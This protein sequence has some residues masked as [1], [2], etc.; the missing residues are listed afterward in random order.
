MPGKQTRPDAAG[1]ARCDSLQ[2]LVESLE[3]YGETTALTVFAEEGRRDVGFGALVRE[4]RRLAQAMAARGIGQ[5]TPVALFGTNSLD[6]VFC[7]FALI[8]ADALCVPIDFDADVARLQALVRDSGATHL[9]VSH[10]KLPTARKA[11]E[12]ERL[13]LELV[14][15]DAPPDADLDAPRLGE[16]EAPGPQE[17][18]TADPDAPV[19]RF[20]TSG[21]TGLPKAVPLSHRNILIN[22]EVLHELDLVGPGDAVLLPLPLHHSYPFIVGLLLPLWAGATV[23][24]PQGASGPA[25][26]SAL[27]EAGVTVIVGVPRLYEALADGIDRRIRGSGLLVGGLLRG[28]IAISRTLRRRFG[29]RVGRTLLAPLHRQLGP[30]LRLLVSGGAKLDEGVAWRLEA[31]GFQVL[32][33]YGLVE[34]TSVATFNPPG[35]ARLGSAGKVSRA[36]EVRLQPLPDMQHGEV[37]IRG[38]VLF[39]GYANSPEANA[40]SFTEDGWFRTGDLGELDAQGYLYIRGRAKEVIVLPGGKNVAPGD[41]EDVYGGSPHIREIAVLERGDRLVGLVVPESAPNE[42]ASKLESRIRVAIGELGQQLPGYMRLSDFVLT[43]EELPRNQLGKFKRHQ[44]EPIYDRAERGEAAAPRELSEEEKRT[45]ATPRARATLALLEAWYPDRRLHPDTSLQMELGI[46]SLAWVELSLEL[47]RRLGVSLGDEAMM[48]VA[49]L[50]DLLEAVE[51]APESRGGEDRGARLLRE[52]ERWLAEPGLAGRVAGGL[53]Y[54]LGWLLAHSYF[55]LS[56]SGREKVPR[57]GPLLV[58]ANHASD[59][60]GGILALALPRRTYRQTWWSGDAGR[61]FHTR[62]HRAFSRAQHIF[63]VDER[64][65]GAALELAGELLHRDRVLAWFP[66]EWRSPDGELQDFRPGIGVLV[67]RHRVPVLPCVIEGAFEVMPRT[68]RLP[69]PGRLRVRFGGPIAPEELLP[70]REVT[71]EAERHRRIA[72]A[73]RDRIAALQADG[74]QDAAGDGGGLGRGGRGRG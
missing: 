70:G 38:P 43:R 65:P 34:T 52:R 62:L 37:Q 68:A 27:Q 51:A 23:A 26:L 56:V 58:A 72:A 12:D 39:P 30:Q 33:G 42:A 8:L 31:L 3:R 2:A 61:L 20:Y 60:D 36:A 48:Q 21:T 45:L 6:W 69:K 41:V 29:L 19:A 1:A 22:I 18:P 40:E 15:L 7:R 17:L 66:E 67:D 25:L 73:L 53:I 10:D 11:V 49:T 13:E 47:E 44:L 28:L 63:P 59:I 55:R 64:S 71:D 24:F 9:F 57:E 4:S 54:G 5:G 50:A 74:A 32:S 46:D 16:L 14:V 35:E